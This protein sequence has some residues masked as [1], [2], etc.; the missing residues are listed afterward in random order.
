MVEGLQPGYA[1]SIPFIEVSAPLKPPW[2]PIP[3]QLVHPDGGGPT[4]RVGY[5]HPL[6]CLSQCQP[7]LNIT[8]I[9][10]SFFLPQPVLGF[11]IWMFLGLPD[12]D[13]FVRVLSGL[14]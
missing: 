13:P 11:Q 7:V 9:S 3:V 12:P 6:H 14:Q 10:Q 2:F 4:A 1:N 8:Q 5:Q